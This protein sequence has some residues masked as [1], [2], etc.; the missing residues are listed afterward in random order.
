MSLIAGVADHA[1][2]LMLEG[3]WLDQTG[4][5]RSRRIQHASNIG[6]VSQVRQAHDLRWRHVNLASPV[7]LKRGPRLEPY[8]FS[9]L[10]IIVARNLTALGGK[11]TLLSVVGDDEAGHALE[12]LMANETVTTSRLRDPSSSKRPSACSSDNS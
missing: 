10:K 1:G 7:L 3:L 5:F 4:T 12:R 6:I 2:A 11:A 8:A 9:G